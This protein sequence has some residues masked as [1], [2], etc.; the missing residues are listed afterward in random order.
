MNRQILKILLCA[1]VVILFMACGRV[2]SKEAYLE[3]F[4]KFVTQLEKKDSIPQQELTSIKKDYL[5]YA[6]T[7]YNKYKEEMTS[8]EK[9][10][11]IKLKAR[12]HSV[13]AKQGFKDVE[14]ALEELGGQAGDLINSI[15]K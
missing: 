7:Y 4:D 15:F 8:D 14:K 2:N 13:I 3:S 10:Q 11:V 6:E 12:Y 5:D 1:C 9:G